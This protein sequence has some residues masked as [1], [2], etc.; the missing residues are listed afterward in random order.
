MLGKEKVSLKTRTLIETEVQ[1]IHEKTE[2]KV[3]ELVAFAGVSKSTWHEWKSRKGI[4]TRHNHET[5]KL[6]WYT[7]EERKAVVKYVLTHKNFL[8]GYRYLAWQMIDENVAFVRPASVYN[9][10]KTKGK[11]SYC[12]YKQ[13]SLLAATAA[14]LNHLIS[15]P[16]KVQVHFGQDSNFTNSKEFFYIFLS[17]Y[18]V[19]F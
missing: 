7:P 19:F 14:G 17:F 12:R 4:E 15:F 10:M 13:K 6:N 2:I 1:K 16:K 3:S 18:C 9:I 5:P 8:Y 11:T